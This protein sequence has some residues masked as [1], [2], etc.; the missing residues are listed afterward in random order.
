MRQPASQRPDLEHLTGGERQQ[1]AVALGRPSTRTPASAPTTATWHEPRQRSRVPPPVSSN[2]PR[3]GVVADQAVGQ[4]ER[5][6]VGRPGAGNPDRGDGAATAVLDDGAQ[7]RPEDLEDG[8]G[9]GR[10]A[11]RTEAATGSGSTGWSAPA[12][13]NWTRSPG[14]STA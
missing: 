5:D 8:P 1:L 9:V 14:A 12:T 3:T 7:A 10:R 4:V 13:A 6:R 11:S 2:A